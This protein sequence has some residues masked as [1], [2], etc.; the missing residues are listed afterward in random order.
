VTVALDRIGTARR[1]IELLEE[2]LAAEGFELLDVRVFVGGGRTTLRVFLDAEGGINLAGCSK[3]SRT[4]GMLLE[5]ADPIEEAYVVEIS[6]P[7]IRRPLRTSAHYEAAVGEKIILKLFPGHGP[8]TVKGT[9]T[10]WDDG[11]MS[12]EQENEAGRV[13]IALDYVREGNLDPDFDPRKLIGDDRR[14]R[15]DDRRKARE[16]RRKER[17]GR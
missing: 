7:G 8:R 12:I 11:R 13:W 10:A 15:K 14:R 17:G 9:M 5:E 2:P 6:S 4:A 1:V 3:A 16:T